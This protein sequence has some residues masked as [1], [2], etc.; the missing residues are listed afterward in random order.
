MGGPCKKLT[1]I[2]LGESVCLEDAVWGLLQV[3]SW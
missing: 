1:E 2:P 3:D